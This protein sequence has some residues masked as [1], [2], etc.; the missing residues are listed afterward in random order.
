MVGTRRWF[1]VVVGLS[2]ALLGVMALRAER[3]FLSWWYPDADDRGIDTAL[4]IDTRGGALVQVGDRGSGTPSNGGASPGY[5]VAIEARAARSSPLSIRLV[6]PDGDVAW[7]RDIAA[8]RRARLRQ[9]VL[10]RSGVWRVELESPG[11]VGEVAVRGSFVDAPWSRVPGGVA[12]PVAWVLGGLVV[13]TSVWI[14]RRGARVAASTLA[15]IAASCPIGLLTTYWIFQRS[16][17]DG[18]LA[19]LTVGLTASAWVALGWTR[20][21][22]DGPPPRRGEVVLG[23]IGAS[24]VFVTLMVTTDGALCRVACRGAWIRDGLWPAAVFTLTGL[25]VLGVGS[26]RVGRHTATSAPGGVRLV[27]LDAI[28]TVCALAVLPALGFGL[29]AAWFT[30]SGIGFADQGPD[31]G[32]GFRIL[33]MT[34]VLTAALVL[35]AVG[36]FRYDHA[37]HIGDA[38]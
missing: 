24:V 9:T 15:V 32:A 5:L 17:G 13:A 8:G 6:S 7:S 26:W 27:A 16:P 25:V 22:P 29:F 35:A 12:L 36:S 14:G 4:E 31:R 10:D 28:G 30:A 23:T 2:V 21:H 37:P 34:L 1:V 20:P 18:A 38:T 11:K 3:T 33:L 19:A